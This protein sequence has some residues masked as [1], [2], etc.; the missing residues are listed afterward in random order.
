MHFFLCIVDM[1]SSSLSSPLNIA[2]ANHTTSG[3]DCICGERLS[4]LAGMDTEQ[5][6]AHR[7]G[8]KHQTGTSMPLKP[9]RQLAV[10]QF[11][12]ATPTWATEEV[13]PPIERVMLKMTLQQ[14]TQ[15]HRVVLLL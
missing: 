5:F 6:A 12:S 9:K 11:S 14:M 15:R 4:V 8:R 1:S 10:T 3:W 2:W 7:Q 13:S